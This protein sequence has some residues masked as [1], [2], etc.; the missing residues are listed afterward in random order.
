[1]ISR[2]RER[3][4]RHGELAPWSHSSKGFGLR[5][6]SDPCTNHIPD[7]GGANQRDIACIAPIHFTFMY[8]GTAVGSVQFSSVQV[9]CGNQE[10]LKSAVVKKLSIVT[11]LFRAQVWRSAS[12][13]DF[14]I[15]SL[16]SP[17]AALHVQVS[18][19][20]CT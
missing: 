11:L 9:D 1:M 20:Y 18:N 10:P 2:D 15:D 4:V 12:S 14:A 5:P 13:L 17:A 16:S 8:N 19:D 6:F 7:L 3:G